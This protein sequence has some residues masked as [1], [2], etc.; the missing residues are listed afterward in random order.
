MLIILSPAKT[1]DTT[2]SS[3]KLYTQ[4]YYL[5]ESYKIIEKLKKFSTK[6]LS[7]LMSIS[8][9]L[10]QANYDRFQLW[11][12]SHSLSNSKQAILSYKG[13]VFTGLNA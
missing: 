3:C 9:K 10:S 13:E 7:E 12:K 1:I 2:N 5:N 11:N 8:S 6:R 4:P